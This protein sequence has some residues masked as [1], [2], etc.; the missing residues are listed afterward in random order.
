MLV[1]WEVT[2]RDATGLVAEETLAGLLPAWRVVLGILVSDHA[3]NERKESRG[4]R[5]SRR[6][7]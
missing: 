1:G 2:R 3:R 5:R 7:R 4:W 6:V